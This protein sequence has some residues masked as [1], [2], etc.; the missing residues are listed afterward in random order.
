ME[1]KFKKLIISSV[2]FTAKKAL[3][4][5]HGA[6]RQANLNLEKARDYWRF[7]MG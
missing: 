6:I 4:L 3:I 7:L 1:R 5:S 2:N